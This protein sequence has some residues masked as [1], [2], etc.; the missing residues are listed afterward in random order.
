MLGWL[1]GL[2]T[3]WSKWPSYC[4][5]LTFFKNHT[6]CCS[7]FH[8]PNILVGIKKKRETN[9][10][11]NSGD[12]FVVYPHPWAIGRQPLM[13]YTI[14]FYGRMDEVVKESLS[15][16]NTKSKK[17]CEQLFYKKLAFS[18]VERGV[19]VTTKFQGWEAKKRNRNVSNN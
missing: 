5:Y 16:I 4:K 13:F 8:F 12:T 15:N 1:V 3:C 19:W 7:F 14:H 10:N 17:L 6:T 18:R 11:Y 9:N 2:W